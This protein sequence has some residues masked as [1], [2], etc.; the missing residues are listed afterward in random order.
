MILF[1]FA[2]R[3]IRLNWLRSSFAVVGIV[4]GVAAISTMGILGNGLALSIPDNLTSVGNTIVITPHISDA[5]GSP[6]GGGSGLKITGV[7]L[8]EI[9][10]AAGSNTVI[11]I[12]IGDD[13]IT[14]GGQSETVVL[15]AMAP[16]DIPVLLEKE[17]GSYPRYGSGVMVGEKLASENSLEVGESLGIGSGE[18]R[19]RIVGILKERGVGLDISP[20]YA[21]IVPDTWFTARYGELNYDEVVIKVTN[22]DDIDGVKGAV[23]DMLNQREQVVNVLDT[24]KV[25]MTIVDTF[26]QVSAW[27]LAVGAISLTVAGISILN[28]MLMSVTE[29]TK[30][31]GIIRALGVKRGEVP[32]G[33]PHRGP[34]PRA[35]GERRRGGPLPRGGVPGPHC[36]APV[37]EVPPYGNHPRFHPVRG[38]LRYRCLA[39]IRDLP[40][41]EGG[42]DKAGRGA[43]VRIRALSLMSLFIHFIT[44]RYHNV[45]INPGQT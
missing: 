8:E 16:A 29:R 27:I 32:E 1:D 24:R 40:R 20:D 43:A 35:R 31:I 12:R 39:H 5:M 28:V 13:C 6:G 19:E 10:S 22:P 4:L 9:R 42:D 23:E 45:Y 2:K 41:L 17:S 34:Y 3:N 7:Q 21:V 33:L 14:V 11:P 44:L 18:E 37:L 25:F 26:N 36:H 30:E 15:Y 38:G